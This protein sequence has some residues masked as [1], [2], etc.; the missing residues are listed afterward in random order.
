MEVVHH[1][2]ESR[3]GGFSPFDIKLMELAQGNPIR[4]VCPYLSLEYLERLIRQCS[5][6]CLLTDI[7]EWLYSITLDQLSPTNN[8]IQS[9]ASHIRHIPNIHAKVLLNDN[10]M[11]IGS[12]NFTYNGIKYREEFSV[13]IDDTELVNQTHSWYDQL[14][15][16][17]DP[18]SAESLES[19]VHKL[20]AK[21]RVSETRNNFFLSSTKPPKAS[22]QPEPLLPKSIKTKEQNKERLVYALKK[23]SDTTRIEEFFKLAKMLID[24]LDLKPNDPRIVTSTPQDGY[25]SIT[26]NQRYVLTANRKSKNYWDFIAPNDYYSFK[27]PSF[28]MI[29]NP[30]NFSP[31]GFETKENAP[32]LISIE[33]PRL[34]NIPIDFISTWL[35][36]CKTELTHGKRSSFFKN[37]HNVFFYDCITNLKTRK[38]LLRETIG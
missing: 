16:I 12:A 27:R 31:K 32:K 18:I 37:S 19:F 33:T 13:L 26:I 23:I 3:K 25:L 28:N 17:A 22:L 10:N 30:E 29:H 34:E 8:F 4:I 5:S 15:N 21:K 35:S 36:L 20:S 1:T 14:W 24:H 7:E 2:D 38:E 9:N 11:F 6:W